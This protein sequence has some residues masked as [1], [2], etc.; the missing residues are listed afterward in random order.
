MAIFI[1]ETLYMQVCSIVSP[2][3]FLLFVNDIIDVVLPV[4]RIKLCTDDT[5]ACL[6]CILDNKVY[7]AVES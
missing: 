4:N 1:T 5:S 2:F 7:T 6:L 3:L